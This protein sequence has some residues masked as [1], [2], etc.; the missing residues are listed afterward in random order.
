MRSPSLRRFCSVRYSI[1][2]WMP[3][4]SRPGTGRSR[5]RVEPPASTSASNSRAQLVD[6]D[7]DADVDA[8]AELDPFLRQQVE[9]AIEE[10][11]LELELR[12]AVAQQAADAI[13]ALE[14]GDPVPGAIQLRGRRQA[15]RPRSD[16]RDA[17]AGAHLGLPAPRP[18]LRRTP[19]R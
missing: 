17:L 15:G 1:A 16:H 14:D 4:S 11:L 8:G 9:P 12:D 5:G 3:E 19:D 6:A 13:G 18:S 10:A 2:K 7:V